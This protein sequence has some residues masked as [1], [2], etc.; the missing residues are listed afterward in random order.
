MQAPK[1]EAYCD[2]NLAILDIILFFLKSFL[3]VKY[4]EHKYL[5]SRLSFQRQIGGIG[6]EALII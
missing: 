1:A 4:S 5:N 3:P 6:I 2:S